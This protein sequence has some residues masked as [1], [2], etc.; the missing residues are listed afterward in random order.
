MFMLD[1]LKLKK[2]CVIIHKWLWGQKGTLLVIA[3]NII[4]MQM[5][6]LGQLQVHLF[7]LIL[8]NLLKRVI[9]KLKLHKQFVLILLQKMTQKSTR[10]LNLLIMLFNKIQNLLFS[11]QHG[12][13][14]KNTDVNQMIWAKRRRMNIG[15]T[16]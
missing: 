2:I 9:D 8:S 14:V 12:F 16:G 4:F 11:Q 15:S 1:M 3:E 5:I 6:L 13:S 7:N 10:S